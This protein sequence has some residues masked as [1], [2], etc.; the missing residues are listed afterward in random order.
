M[1]KSC[2]SEAL[3]MINTFEEYAL[4]MP[5]LLILNYLSKAIETD[6]EIKPVTHI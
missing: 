3:Q 5:S 6:K 1:S 4:P 2:F